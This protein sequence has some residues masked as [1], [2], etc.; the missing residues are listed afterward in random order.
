MSALLVCAQPATGVPDVVPKIGSAELLKN[1]SI[2]PHLNPIKPASSLEM[3]P[4]P[5]MVSS[6]ISEFNALTK[7]LPRGCLTEICGPSSSG[8]TSLLLAALA[9]STRRDEAS[10]LVDVSNTLDPYS[11]AAAGM[12]FQKLLWIRCGVDNSTSDPNPPIPEFRSSHFP[13]PFAAI[14]DHNFSP[15]PR[16]ALLSTDHAGENQLAVKPR[17]M[18]ARIRTENLKP[19]QIKNLKIKQPGQFG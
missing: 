11:A 12:D 2:A 4:A 1:L 13:H 16:S 3:R 10:A 7:G 19:D 15:Q 8:R 17:N 9:A 14:P 5:E 6:G 18:I